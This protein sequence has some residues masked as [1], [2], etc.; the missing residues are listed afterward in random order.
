MLLLALVI[1]V[2][3][4]LSQVGLIGDQSDM[5]AS[6]GR[7]PVFHSFSLGRYLVLELYV[8]F[9]A[10]YEACILDLPAPFLDFSMRLSH[11]GLN[12]LLWPALRSFVQAP[13]ELG[14][15]VDEAFFAMFKFALTHL[16]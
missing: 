4:E 2:V 12:F 9:V 3:D 10:R 1:E 14:L 7:F 13:D 5:S 6:L 16:R 8:A 15:D 11:V